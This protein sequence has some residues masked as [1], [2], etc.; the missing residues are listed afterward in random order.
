MRIFVPSRM[1]S[2]K[3]EASHT[4]LKFRSAASPP[5]EP[6]PIPPSP[7]LPSTGLLL[8]RMLEHRFYITMQKSKGWTVI[9]RPHARLQ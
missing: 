7:Y 1:F 5:F 2:A 6:T 4:K 3:D 9:A 8:P